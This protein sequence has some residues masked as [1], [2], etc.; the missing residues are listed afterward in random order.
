MTVSSNRPVQTNKQELLIISVPKALHIAIRFNS[1]DLLSINT[2]FMPHNDLSSSKF[3]FEI[4]PFCLGKD[5][6]SFHST[7]QLFKTKTTRVVNTFGTR[8]G[9]WEHHVLAHQHSSF[10]SEE[11]TRTSEDH[12]FPIFKYQGISKSWTSPHSPIFQTSSLF[13]LKSERSSLDVT[14]ALTRNMYRCSAKAG[15]SICMLSLY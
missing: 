3:A 8:S 1:A 9:F 5:H 4:H 11:R 2:C 6:I 15:C 7:H 10:L 12:P 13:N 14:S